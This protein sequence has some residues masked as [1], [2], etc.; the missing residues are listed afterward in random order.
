M[1]E[2]RQLSSVERKIDMEAKKRIE[3]ELEYQKYLLNH[4]NLMIGQG[5]YQNYKRQLKEFKMKKKDAEAQI[6]EMYLGLNAINLHLTKGVPVKK[7]D[8]EEGKNGN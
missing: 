7:E 1:V 4:A 5:L 3:G 6:Q 2:Y 8:D